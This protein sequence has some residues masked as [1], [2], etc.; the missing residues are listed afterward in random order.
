M[1]IQRHVGRKVE[2]LRRGKGW[3]QEKLGFESGF[4]RTYISQVERGITNPTLDSLKRIAD[5]LSV[6]CWELI[7][8]M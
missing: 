3:S 6:P 2:K 1:D 4:H 5:T 7:E 8:P